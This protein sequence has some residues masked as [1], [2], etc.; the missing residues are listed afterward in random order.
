MNQI[1]LSGQFER[2]VGLSK[3]FSLNC[4]NYLLNIVNCSL[5]KNQTI[6]QINDKILFDDNIHC[7]DNIDRFNLL[8]LKETSLYKDTIELV[9]VPGS[10]NGSGQIFLEHFTVILA[11]YRDENF[12]I[13][14]LC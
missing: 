3:L 9:F 8:M 12:N 4:A 6:K 5:L 11:I 13:S 14:G 1:Y 10:Y 2:I 7:F